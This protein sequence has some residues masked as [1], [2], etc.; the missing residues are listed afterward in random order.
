MIQIESQEVVVLT[1]IKI[2]NASEYS[3]EFSI[4]T[5]ILF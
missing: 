3:S 1:K 5:L 2:A 4:V